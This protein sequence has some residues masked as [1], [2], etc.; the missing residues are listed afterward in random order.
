MNNSDKVVRPDN[1]GAN[2]SHGGG[3]G[4][5]HGDLPERVAKLEVELKHLA[6]KAWILG[7]ALFVVV[8]VVVTVGAG[9]WYLSGTL[10]TMDTK[11]TAVEASF[12]SYKEFHNREHDISR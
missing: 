7:S 3:S 4:G 5:S 11:L 8:S 12:D 9:V 6:T 1:W 10:A 2:P